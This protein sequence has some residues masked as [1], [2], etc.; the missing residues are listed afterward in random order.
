MAPRLEHD[1]RGSDDVA[2]LTR[3]F[4]EALNAPDHDATRAPLAED[5][6]LRGDLDLGI[7]AGSSPGPR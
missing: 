5:V 2:A 7:G 3:L 6:E 1:R 4:A